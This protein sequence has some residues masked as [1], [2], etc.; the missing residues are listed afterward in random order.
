VG[1]AYQELA[2]NSFGQTVM[3]HRLNALAGLRLPGRL[4]LLAQGT[5][6][7]D[8]YPDGVFL[9]PEIIL[10]ED[11]E[12]QN[13]LSLRLVRPLG[14]R[15]DLELSFGWYGTRLPRNDLTYSRQ[16]GSL[17]VSWRL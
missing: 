1:Y 13:V 9:S 6:A 16:V 10:A 12:G 15:L 7:L 3:R 14:E 4:T 17:G 2:S 5:L 11:D 8:R